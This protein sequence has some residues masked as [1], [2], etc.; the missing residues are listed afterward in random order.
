LNLLIPEGTIFE[1]KIHWTKSFVLSGHHPNF[2]PGS[3]DLAFLFGSVACVLSSGGSAAIAFSARLFESAAVDN[4]EPG[5][6]LSTFEVTG[7]TKSLA[8]PTTLDPGNKT[9][10]SAP[11]RPPAAWNCRQKGSAAVQTAKLQTRVKEG[12]RDNLRMTSSSCVL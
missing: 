11:L 7:G 8:L 1:Q 2:H 10:T 6:V 12:S 9:S 4:A 5:L 3:C